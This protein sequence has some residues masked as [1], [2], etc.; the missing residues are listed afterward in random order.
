MCDYCVTTG[1]GVFGKVH[2][3]TYVP[4]SGPA[5]SCA[6]KK[7]KTDEA[8]NHKSEILREADAMAALEH[9]HIVRLIGVCYYN[10]TGSVKSII[11]HTIFLTLHKI[12]TLALLMKQKSLHMC[13]N[14]WRILILKLAE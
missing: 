9:P 13:R 10:V 8:A 14:S 6:L 11:S 2:E 12:R 7:L 1:A 4:R 3:G 5:V